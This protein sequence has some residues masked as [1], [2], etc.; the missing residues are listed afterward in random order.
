MVLIEESMT[1][2]M[3]CR[4]SNRRPQEVTNI[5]RANVTEGGMQEEG[6]N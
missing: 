1:R 4:G 6:K 2:T 5:Q 3:G